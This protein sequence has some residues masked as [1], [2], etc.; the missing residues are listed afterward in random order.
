MFSISKHLLLFFSKGEAHSTQGLVQNLRRIS[1]S[2]F[3]LMRSCWLCGR[4]VAPN[5][6]RSRPPLLTPE[7]RQ[8]DTV[9][10]PAFAGREAASLRDQAVTLQRT[11]TAGPKNTAA[12]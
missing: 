7:P 6:S 5:P 11:E 8:Q 12:P 2:V 4:T 1:N 3:L 9:Q 10:P